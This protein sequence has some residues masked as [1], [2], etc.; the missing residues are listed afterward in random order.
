MRMTVAD[1]VAATGGTLLRGDRGDAFTDATQDSRRVVPGMLFI[2][3]KGDRDGHDF[4][5]AALDAGAAG[6]LTE[7]G[8]VAAAQG[9]FAIGVGDTLTALAD[10]GRL[11]RE[12]IPDVAAI[13]GSA[14]KTTTKDFLAAI[15]SR[16][17][18]TGVAPGSHNNEIGMPL[19]LVNAPDAARIVVSEIGARS[20]GDV[21][22]GAELVQPTVGVV[23]NVGSAHLGVF[24][25][26]E[27][28]AR[29]KGELV[30]ALD[31]DGVA[32]LN[33]DDALVAE[34]AARTRARVV[35]FSADGDRAADVSVAASRFAPDLSAEFVLETP[36][37]RIECETHGAGPHILS[38]AAG[39]A[40][41][42]I[43]LG[44]SADDVAAGLVGT[45]R[46][47]HRMQLH[48][49]AG[50]WRVLDDAY[51]ANPESMAAALASAAGVAGADGRTLALLGHM[52]ELGPAAADAHRALADL[53]RGHGFDV[54][55]SVGEHAELVS[56][57]VARDPAEAAELLRRLAG[58]FRPGDVIVVKA[59][60]VVGLEAAVPALLEIRTDP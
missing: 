3:I 45:E 22:W 40:A 14:G 33:A 11:A 2:P 55:V 48:A 58:G 20:P 54:V 53:H 51:N 28:I 39:A 13:T 30:E 4:V 26:R 17:A 41:A 43:A 49:S 12:R 10:L 15:V 50:G 27:A 6:Y 56:D 34:M 59:S 1:A 19:T 36:V 31:V 21:R 52:A 60:R 8:D 23:T 46:S 29:T 24:G 44:A 5:A 32:V 37:G 47:A 57:N 18:V 25:S 16:V 35:T 9:T 7:R 38:C 42:A